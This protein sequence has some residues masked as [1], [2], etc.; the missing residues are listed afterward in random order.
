MKDGWDYSNDGVELDGRF[1][2]VPAKAYYQREE[3]L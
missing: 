1:F 3:Q 2:H